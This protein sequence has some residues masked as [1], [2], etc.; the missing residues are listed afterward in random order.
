MFSV[1][2]LAAKSGVSANLIYGW[3]NT[4]SLAHVRL[5]A[6]GKRGRIG[7]LEAD[8]EAFLASRRI[9]V[10]NPLA[11]PVARPSVKFKHLRVR[12]ARDSRRLEDGHGRGCDAHSA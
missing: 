9:E 4:G 5:G 12:P 3:C 11:S 7:I 2:Q 6:V 10:G 8:W 1:R